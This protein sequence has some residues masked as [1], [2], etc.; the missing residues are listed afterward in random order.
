MHRN[1]VDEDYVHHPVNSVNLLKRLASISQWVPKLNIKIQLLNSA[2]DSFLLQEDYQNALFGL[3]DLREFVN[4]NTLKLAKG[5][6]HNHIT[7]EKFFASSGLSSSDLMKIAS[8]ARKS[9]YLEGYVDW[10]KT[11]LKRAQQEGKN[12]DF[13]SK[14]R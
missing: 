4:I 6:I 14:I 12:V 10:L 5:I 11:A 7:G 2:N 13:I 9:N 1:T 8:E 3:A